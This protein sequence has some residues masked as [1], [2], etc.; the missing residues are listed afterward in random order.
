MAGSGGDA[1]MGGFAGSGGAGGMGGSGGSETFCVPGAVANCYDGPMGTEGVGSCAPGTKVCN[2]SGMDFGPC[3]GAITPQTEDCTTPI[4]EDCSEVPDCGDHLWSKRFGDA[5]LQNAQGAA[6]DAAGN[7]YLIGYFQGD[8]DFGG[9]VLTSAGSNDVYIAKF[10]SDGN[11]VWSK[12]FGDG[13]NQRGQAIVLDS[14]GNLY[15]SGWFGGTIDLGGGPLTGTGADDSFLA[16]LG[17]DGSHIWSKA[18][19]GLNNQ[20]IEDIAVDETDGIVIVGDFMGT[21]DLGGGL[22]SSAGGA[23]I[24]LAK[25]APNGAFVWGKR[26]GSAGD[27]IGYAARVAP[28]GNVVIAGDINGSTNFGGG[29]LGSA[30]GTDIFVASFDSLGAHQWSKLFGDAAMQRG[31]TLAVDAAG[32]VVLSGYIEGAVDFGGG[33]LT[34]GGLR[35]HFVTKLDATGAHVWSKRFG[36]AGDDATQNL[37]LDSAGNIVFTGHFEAAVDY[38]GG[39]LS[40]AGLRDIVVA[41]LSPAGEHVWSRRFG[42]ADSQSGQNVAT[43]AMGHVYVFSD[44]PGTIDY[45]GGLLTSDSGSLDVFIAKLAP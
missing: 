28:S 31:E 18:F 2:P 23:D 44:N 15:V 17:A 38:G 9:G 24:F 27:Q 32:A 29:I 26:F 6:V 30:G 37:A 7:V 11:H 21:I 45:G 3:M 41:K 35:D 40:S 5:L 43:D 33:T 20:R 10:D 39:P 8:I 34:S 13:N 4:D 12:R 25:Y 42:D 22:V 14:A 16:K 1:G 19:G 36:A